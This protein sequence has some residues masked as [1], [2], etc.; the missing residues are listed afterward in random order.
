MLW[1][2]WGFRM[3]VFTLRNLEGAT[4]GVRLATL[5]YNATALPNDP[6]SPGWAVARSTNVTAAGA[7]L[8]GLQTVYVQ[9]RKET[10]DHLLYFFISGRGPLGFLSHPARTTLDDATRCAVL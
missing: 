5:T 10:E 9:V 1:P 7:K 4:G 8:G 2:I 3:L 6:F